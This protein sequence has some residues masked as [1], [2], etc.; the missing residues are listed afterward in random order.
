MVDVIV[1]QGERKVRHERY[2]VAAQR[3]LHDAGLVSNVRQQVAVNEDAEQTGAYVEVIVWI[4][5]AAIA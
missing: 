1:E 3:L 2:R 5:R 4:P